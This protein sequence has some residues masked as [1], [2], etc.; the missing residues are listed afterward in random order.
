MTTESA[1]TAATI[2]TQSGLTFQIERRADAHHAEII[3]STETKRPC[4][5]HWGLRRPGQSGWDQP[6]ESSWPPGTRAAGGTAAQT[7]LARREGQ[8][9]CAVNL[10]ED[11]LYAS[12]EFV[13][14][15][16]DEGHWD[17]NRGR[18]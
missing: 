13:L 18:N 12:L 5:L 17:N 7:P 3:F 11:Q 1:S 4:V 9:R 14:F 6:P 2:A 16:P 8:S 15:F 10:P